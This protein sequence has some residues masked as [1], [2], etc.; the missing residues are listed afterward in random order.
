ML[1]S[2]RPRPQ[3]ASRTAL[4]A[5]ALDTRAALF[6]DWIHACICAA[7]LAALHSTDLPPW[8]LTIAEI[9]PDACLDL[10]PLPIPHCMRP[11]TTLR[12]RGSGVGS[13]REILSGR[14]GGEGRLVHYKPFVTLPPCL[15][16]TL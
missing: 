13:G 10:D 16:G 6:V 4:P 15:S 11:V 14:D 5:A 2:R 7:A 9:L 12:A 8:H 1:T 3:L